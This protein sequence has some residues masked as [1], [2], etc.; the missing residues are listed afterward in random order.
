MLISAGKIT[1]AG[2]FD[3]YPIVGGSH[4]VRI[5]AYK[6]TPLCRA[7]RELQVDITGAR[8]GG[9]LPREE[10]TANLN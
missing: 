8:Y 5:I 4:F 1:H 10:E 9:A 6:R 2:R 7:M 3:H